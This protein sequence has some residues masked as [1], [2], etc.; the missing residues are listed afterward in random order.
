MWKSESE[1]KVIVDGYIGERG[2]QDLHSQLDIVNNFLESESPSHRMDKISQQWCVDKLDESKKSALSELDKKDM[3]ARYELLLRWLKCFENI[4]KSQKVDFDFVIVSASYFTSSFAKDDLKKIQVYFPNHH[5]S[6][7]LKEL[8]ELLSF[9][10]SS[11]DKF[12]YVY[13]SCKKKREIDI[14]AIGKEISKTILQA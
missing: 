11:R 5:K 14:Q 3:I 9:K 7:E 2:Y 10:K 13:Y 1:Y 6:Y 12:F 4:S 8:I